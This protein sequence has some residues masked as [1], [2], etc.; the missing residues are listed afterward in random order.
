MQEKQ[1]GKVRRPLLLSQWS[2]LFS[3]TKG[4]ERP[5]SPNINVCVFVHRYSTSAYF[6]PEGR[7]ISARINR[8]R[9]F[10][11]TKADVFGQYFRHSSQCTFACHFRGPKSEKL[12]WRSDSSSI[13]QPGA[14]GGC[15][16]SY[17][18]CCGESADKSPLTLRDFTTQSWKRSP[19][20]IRAAAPCTWIWI[21]A[22]RLRV[23]LSAW[24]TFPSNWGLVAVFHREPRIEIS[25]MIWL[26]KSPY[27]DWAS[28]ALCGQSC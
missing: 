20:T 3:G 18:P 10:L 6:C 15:A 27:L 8:H 4:N 23:H 2:V 19:W 26:L 24:T 17:S 22:C 14:D 7:N 25:R 12:S 11:W 5:C 16:K 13:E 1:S 9:S 28:L 21:S